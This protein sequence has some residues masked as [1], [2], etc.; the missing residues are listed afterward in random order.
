MHKKLKFHHSNYLIYILIWTA[1]YLVSC[2]GSNQDIAHL[3]PEFTLEK[4]DSIIVKETERLTILDC[5]K[6][7]NTLLVYMPQSLSVL[8]VT[9]QGEKLNKFSLKDHFELEH[10][11]L[12]DHIGYY[13]DSSIVIVTP[14]GYFF[15]TMKGALINKIEQTA[16]FTAGMFLKIKPLKQGTENLLVS[17]RPSF[18]DPNFNQR[19]SREYYNTFKALTLFNLNKGES[20]REFGF[21]N[22]SVFKKFD[23]YYTNRLYYFDV[24]SAKK[25][26]YLLYNPNHNVYVYSLNHGI[27]LDTIVPTQPDYFNLSE[28]LPFKSS[29]SGDIDRILGVNSQY[30]SVNAFDDYIMTS[31][32]TGIPA[33]KYDEMRSATE[34]TNY[35]K[36]YNKNFI[37]IFKGYKKMGSDIEL[38]QDIYSIAIFKSLDCIIGVTNNLYIERPDG[39]VFYVYKL[40]KI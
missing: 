32:S 30:Y 3:K 37:Q 1:I 36:K 39:E 2:A 27:H 40:K 13:S 8:E 16:P 23:Y 18:Q 11:K 24:D 31:Y 4:V 14:K 22:N 33:D 17:V 20:H 15:Y 12:I 9:M 7:K 34:Y 6:T 28:K 10:G 19:N 29:K 26:V 25:L 21:E 5:N 35:F 38:P